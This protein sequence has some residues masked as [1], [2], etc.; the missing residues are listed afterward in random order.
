MI[1]A[2]IIGMIGQY[3]SYLSKTKNKLGLVP[4]ITIRE[5][6]T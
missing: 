1:K 2:L 3:G 5:V 6:Y 4:E